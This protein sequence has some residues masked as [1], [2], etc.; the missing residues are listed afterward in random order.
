MHPLK[1]TSS[2]KPGNRLLFLGVKCA[3]RLSWVAVL[4]GMVLF[5]ACGRLL[6]P[7]PVSTMQFSMDGVKLISPDLGS[8]QES[9]SFLNS[10]YAL[11]SQ[12]R[13]LVRLEN[14]LDLVERVS[15]ENGKKV[16]MHIATVASEN[17]EAAAQSLELC[18]I[19]RNWMML[20]NWSFAHPFSGGE[21][22]NPGADFDAFSCQTGSVKENTRV[23]RFDITQWFVDY[24]RGRRENFGLILK[25]RD[26]VLRDS[27]ANPEIVVIG[28]DVSSFSPKLVFDEYYLGESFVSSEF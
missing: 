16:W 4:I 5:T 24:P 28:D 7:S 2:R 20:A 25:I 12:S 22:K 21:W 1:F 9:Q 26:S 19:T 23:I 17:A 10:R 27:Q 18:P 14:L 15:V 13:L 3:V 8:G 6:G 11:T